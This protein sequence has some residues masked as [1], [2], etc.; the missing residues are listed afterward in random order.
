MPCTKGET[1]ISAWSSFGFSRLAAVTDE[2]FGHK[3]NNE[4]AKARLVR[5]AFT[6]YPP[7][8]HKEVVEV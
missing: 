6:A 3:A 5:T 7:F 2:M 1:L 4:R 8:L